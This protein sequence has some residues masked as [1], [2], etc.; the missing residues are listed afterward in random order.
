MMLQSL[1]SRDGLVVSGLAPGI[2]V[3]ASYPILPAEETP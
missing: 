2:P 1:A 3:F